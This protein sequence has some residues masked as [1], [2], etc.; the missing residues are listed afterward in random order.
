MNRRAFIRVAVPFGFAGAIT[1]AAEKRPDR[2]SGVVKSVDLARHRIEMRMRNGNVV[3][4]INYDA[5]TRFM[6]NRKPG[7]VEDVKEGLRVVAIGK[8]EGVD[9]N[10]TNISITAR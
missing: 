4:V 8:F 9:L 10:A 5:N 2:L 7:K 6:F 1:L 3:R